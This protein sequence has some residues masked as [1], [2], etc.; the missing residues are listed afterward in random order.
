MLRSKRSAQPPLHLGWSKAAWAEVVLVTLVYP[1]LTLIATYPAMLVGWL[2]YA[3][4]L[5]YIPADQTPARLDD[6]KGLP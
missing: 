5:R 3:N 6:A 4:D 1:L 2:Q